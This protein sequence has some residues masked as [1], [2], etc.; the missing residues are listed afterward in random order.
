MLRVCISCLYATQF[1]MIWRSSRVGMATDLSAS[2]HWG[3]TALVATSAI[4][5]LYRLQLT[6]MRHTTVDPL[7]LLLLWMARKCICT[8]HS[9]PAPICKANLQEHGCWGECRWRIQLSIFKCIWLDVC[10][11]ST[12]INCSPKTS[13][14]NTKSIAWAVCRSRWV[15]THTEEHTSHT[16]ITTLSWYFHKLSHVLPSLTYA[17]T[18]TAF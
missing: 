6:V 7:A 2:C 10:K 13:C 14:L 18:T 1:E 12:W 15:F 8:V 16:S 5:L 9:K 4:Q 11:L 3:A 17:C